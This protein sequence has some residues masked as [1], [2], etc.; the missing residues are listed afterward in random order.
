MFEVFALKN[1]VNFQILDKK[2]APLQAV[3]RLNKPTFYVEST[4]N[5]WNYWKIEHLTSVPYEIYFTQTRSKS[6]RIM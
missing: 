2:N 1:L 5:A 4:T 6:K 3:G